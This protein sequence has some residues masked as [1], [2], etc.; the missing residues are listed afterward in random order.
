MTHSE[1]EVLS[2]PTLCE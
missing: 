1:Y 2:V